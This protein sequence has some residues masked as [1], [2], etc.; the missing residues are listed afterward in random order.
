MPKKHYP[1][2]TQYIFSLSKTKEIEAYNMQME[3]S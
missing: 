2:L 3:V 1:I